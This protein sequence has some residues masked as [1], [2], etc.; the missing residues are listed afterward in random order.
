[1]RTIA[2]KKIGSSCFGRM[3]CDILDRKFSVRELVFLVAG[4]LCLTPWISPPLALLLGVVAAQTIGH[5][6]RHL[7]HKLTGMLLKVSVVGL[8]FGMNVHTA[9]RA[10]QEGFV[11]TI[12]SIAGTLL[13]GIL[14]GR[15]FKIEKKTSLLISAG[16]A[17][18]G[19]SAIAAIAPVIDAEEQQISVA[20]GVVFVLNSLAL[21]LFP[22]MGN[23]LHMS[24]HQ[25][26]LWS[27]IAIHDTSSVVGA[28]SRYG[29]EALQ[30]ATTV[31]LARSLWIVPIAAVTAIVFRQKISQIKLPWFI[32][33][34]VAAMLV[35]TWLAAVEP[36]SAVLV[37]GAKTGLTL[38]LFLIGSGLSRDTLEGVG[39][40]P[41][42]QGVMLWA[43]IS[44][45][46]LFVILRFVA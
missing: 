7:N 21:F 10:G 32:G 4:A 13:T 17:I 43:G 30:T 46:S 20:L 14:L 5:P 37:H 45:A 8:G 36:I 31:K 9:L 44:L 33:L 34:F 12:T 3:Q 11:F 24:Q 23:W 18:C 41:M 27:A 1:M 26:G 15:L 22:E 40:Q 2:E 16:T 39:W 42:V 29:S 19:G 6:F 25:F 35:H 28:A 38:T